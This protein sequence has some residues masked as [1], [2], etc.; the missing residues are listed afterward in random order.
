MKKSRKKKLNGDVVSVILI[1]FLF[2][3]VVRSV[4]LLRKYKKKMIDPRKS[5]QKPLLNVIIRNATLRIHL[6]YSTA[7]YVGILCFRRK[8]I[9]AHWC[10]KRT[11]LTKN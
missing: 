5:H 1:I 4:R 2:L 10:Q 7:C 8:D 6:I 11:E 9:Q 3:V